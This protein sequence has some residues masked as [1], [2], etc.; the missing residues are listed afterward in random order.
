[1][2]W[3]TMNAEKEA[4]RAEELLAARRHRLAAQ[5]DRLMAGLYPTAESKRWRQEEIKRQ[6]DAL[7]AARAAEMCAWGGDPCWTAP[8]RLGLAPRFPPS[9]PSAQPHYSPLSPSRRSEPPLHPHWPRRQRR[10]QEAASWQAPAAPFRAARGHPPPA[11]PCWSASASGT[12]LQ[13]RVRRAHAPAIPLLA[14]SPPARLL[15]CACCPNRR[16]C[17]AQPSANLAPCM[18]AGLLDRASVPGRWR[19]VLTHCR[20]S[21]G[22]ACRICMH[23]NKL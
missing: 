3:T 6:Q 4:K 11:V 19:R 1:M 5:H 15:C 2:S 10:S 17:P 16:P 21:A 9:A 18:P 22:A 8:S 23:Q 13:E 20:A 7:A 12:T 14:S